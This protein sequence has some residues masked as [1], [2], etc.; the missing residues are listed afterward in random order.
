MAPEDKPADDQLERFLLAL[1]HMRY[2]AEDATREAGEG[3]KA[4]LGV[5]ALKKDGKTGRIVCRFDAIEFFE[6]I[7]KFLG[8]PPLT[9]DDRMDCAARSIADWCRP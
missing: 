8:V 6:D 3:G 5:L 2:A 7:A 4:Q 9:D 1:K